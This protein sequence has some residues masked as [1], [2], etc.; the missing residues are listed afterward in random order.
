M[1]S[2]I[3]PSSSTL[4]ASAQAAFCARAGHLYALV[5]AMALILRPAAL[6]MRPP[7]ALHIPPG[8]AHTK[9]VR[10][11]RWRL[12]SCSN[13]RRGGC[14]SLL[15]FRPLSLPQRVACSSASCC[16]MCAWML[17][18]A[19]VRE[20][21]GGAGVSRKPACIWLHSV[22]DSPDSA[23]GCAKASDAPALLWTVAACTGCCDRHG[24]PR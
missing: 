18:V 20:T 4:R 22:R 15:L 14:P 21:G 9:L 17:G 10:L 19:A 11:E 1:P 8:L 12:C 6:C 3:V 2:S 7:S 13:F 23:T 16:W 5:Q 24:P